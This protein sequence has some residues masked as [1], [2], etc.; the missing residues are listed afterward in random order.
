VL[1]LPTVNRGGREVNIAF[2]SGKEVDNF[3][4]GDDFLANEKHNKGQDNERV[5][6]E[7]EC[8]NSRWLDDCGPI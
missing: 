8:Y 7:N 5:K 2:L 1:N 3:R 4:V 6:H